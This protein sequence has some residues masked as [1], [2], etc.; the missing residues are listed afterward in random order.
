[1]Y[2]NVEKRSKV[3]VIWKLQNWFQMFCLQ[4]VGI[5]QLEIHTL[6]KIILLC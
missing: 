2:K 1:M 3:V 6:G 4:P 5:S